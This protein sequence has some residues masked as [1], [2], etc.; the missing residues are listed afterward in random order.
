MKRVVV[1]VSETFHKAYKKSCYN[2]NSDMNKK[3][4]ELFGKFVKRQKRAKQR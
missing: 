1:L 4:R 3:S 2:A